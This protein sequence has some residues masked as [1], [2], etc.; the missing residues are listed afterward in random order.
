MPL[1]LGSSEDFATLRELL[2]RHK[3]LEQPIVEQLQ[4]AVGQAPDALAVLV[5]L[6]A[7][8]KPVERGVARE[9]LGDGSVTALIALG[10]AKQADDALEASCLLYPFEDLWI[11]SDFPGQTRE[12]FVFPALSAQS[13]QFHSILPDTPCE[14]LLDIGT[15]A[16]A[17]A[18]S[19]A[20]DYATTV[21]A[22]DVSPRCVL[23]A[24]FNRR[25]NGV[26]NT[27]VQASD[28]YSA[29]AGQ[30]FDRI[31]A[32][33]PYIPTLGDGESY[34][35][36]GAHGEDVL[37]RILEG[38]P[39]YLRPGG[40]AYLSTLGCDHHDCSLDRRVLDMIGAEASEFRVVL[41][42][43]ESLPA[44]EFVMRLVE[45]GE[46][47]FDQG[48]RQVKSFRDAGVTQLV[49]CAIVVSRAAS[50]DGPQVMRRVMGD[51][52]TA[53]QLNAAFSTSGIS[54]DDL[55]DQK[56]VLT[57]WASLEVSSGIDDG[58]WKAYNRI[59]NCEY[60]FRFRTD[61]PEWAADALARLDGTATLREAIGAGEVDLEEAEIFFECLCDAGVLTPPSNN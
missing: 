22:A 25:L 55:L 51:G 5:T 45:V 9:L 12:D 37:R 33:P 29:Y 34:R 35:H 41:A 21:F 24:E 50:D 40:R 26:E 36:G 58:R 59:L 17:A 43:W 10:F 15:G 53:A 47:T 42:E 7:Q 30:T 3:Y 14:A 49:K 8:A 11:A 1:I 18:L 6:F 44:V 31:I 13:S 23:F 52:T 38:L 20:K 32:H 56:L 39:Q 60:P 2:L 48:A 28:V 19:A 16:G 4:S 54:I 57:Q 61:C 27:K 46:L